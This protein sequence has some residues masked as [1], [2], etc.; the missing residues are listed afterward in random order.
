VLCAVGQQ[1]QVANVLAALLQ[2]PVPQPSPDQDRMHALDG[3]LLAAEQLV[4]AVGHG[5]LQPVACSMGALAHQLADGGTQQAGQRVHHLVLQQGLD[6]LLL[7]LPL[8]HLVLLQRHHMLQHGRLDLQQAPPRHL[9]LLGL[10]PLLLGCLP[11]LLGPVLGLPHAAHGMPHLT[12]QG[13][14][15]LVPQACHYALQPRT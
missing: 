6:L 10:Q 2:Q 13:P 15:P 1:L 4:E 3:L 9:H 8:L 11:G 5:C 7:L 14:I 12:P